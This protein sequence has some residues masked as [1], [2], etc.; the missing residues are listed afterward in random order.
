MKSILFYGIISGLFM[1]VS[2]IQLFN[3]NFSSA[4]INAVLSTAYLI[5]AFTHITREQEMIERRKELMMNI[6]TDLDKV[7]EIIKNNMHSQSDK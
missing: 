7:R 6:N 5:I 3:G 1:G 2:I 4:A